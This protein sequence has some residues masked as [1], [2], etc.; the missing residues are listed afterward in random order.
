MTSEEDPADFSKQCIDCIFCS[1]STHMLVNTQS[2]PR[3]LHKHQSILCCS[4]LE[5]FRSWLLLRNMIGSPKPFANPAIPHLFSSALQSRTQHRRGISED[6]RR[7][8][9][10]RKRRTINRIKCEN[11]EAAMVLNQT[12]RHRQTEPQN[13]QQNRRSF[14]SQSPTP[15]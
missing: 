11:V 14:F 12:D 3:L 7:G 10:S 5:G 1:F 4:P 6:T 9:Q 13:H 8:K 2:T 15:P